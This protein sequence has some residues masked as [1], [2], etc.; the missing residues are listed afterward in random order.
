MVLRNRI[1]EEKLVLVQFGQAA[2]FNGAV[3]LIHL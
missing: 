2:F 1:Y 3:G